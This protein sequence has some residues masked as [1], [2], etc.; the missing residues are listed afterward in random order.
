[1]DNQNPSGAAASFNP[2]RRALLASLL[3]AYAASLIPWALAEPVADDGHGAF[4]ALSALLTGRAALDRAQARRLYDAL[5]A[6]DPGFPAAA[7]A[8]L[9][10]VNQRAIDPLDLQRILDAEQ[11]ALAPVPRKIATAWYLG[12]VGNGESARCLAFEAA[13]NAQV[14]ADVLVPPTYAY[15][16]YASWAAKPT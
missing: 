12:I 7:R 3:S 15:G 1:M 5:V 16:P 11:A 8:L 4:V 13:L 14:V 2:R 10:L 6:D 9:A